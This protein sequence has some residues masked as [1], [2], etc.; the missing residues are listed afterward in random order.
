MFCFILFL[1]FVC[2]NWPNDAVCCFRM[3]DGATSRVYTLSIFHIHTRLSLGGCY[4]CCCVCFFVW[5]MRVNTFS[6][7]QMLCECLWLV[8][9]SVSSVDVPCKMQCLP[10]C[11]GHHKNVCKLSDVFLIAAYIVHAM[12]SSANVIYITLHG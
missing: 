2:T 7:H 12:P 5:V 6:G 10:L 4:C 3:L 9:G 8:A 11:Y 1:F